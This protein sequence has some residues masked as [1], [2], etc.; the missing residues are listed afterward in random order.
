M[1]ILEKTKFSNERFLAPTAPLKVLGGS[2]CPFQYMA[3]VIAH[4]RYSWW[5]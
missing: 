2:I 3:K 1:S 5:L 4:S